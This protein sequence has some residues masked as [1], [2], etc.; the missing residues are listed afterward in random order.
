[1]EGRGEGRGGGAGG[2]RG[3]GEA[4]GEESGGGREG[5]GGG[6]LLGLGLGGVVLDPGSLNHIYSMTAWIR[7]QI[8]MI[9]S[10]IHAYLLSVHLAFVTTLIACSWFDLP[11]WI[12][13]LDLLLPPPPPPGRARTFPPSPAPSSHAAGSAF[14][15]GLA[16]AA[17]T[18]CSR[19]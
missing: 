15:P 9:I 14:R 3:R 16:A 12:L 10:W 1:M 2:E 5:R 11:T 17:C 19:P 8:S 4:R 13:D 7:Y 18:R 6:R